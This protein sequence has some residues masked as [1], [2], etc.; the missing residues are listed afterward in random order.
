MKKPDKR[1]FIIRAVAIVMT[2]LMLLS[3]FA[4]VFNTV[5]AASD[6]A[7]PDTGS[8]GFPMWVVFA[9]AGALLVVVLCIVIPKIKKK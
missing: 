6:S 1:S 2:A 3:V 8:D 7:L 5:F 4:I 9:A